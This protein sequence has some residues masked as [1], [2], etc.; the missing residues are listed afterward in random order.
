MQEGPGPAGARSVSSPLPGPPEVGEISHSMAGSGWEEKKQPCQGVGMGKD[1][2][3]LTCELRCAAL[4]GLGV[5]GSPQQ[6]RV[7]SWSRFCPVAAEP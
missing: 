1:R 4:M 5:P 7:C 3:L 2:V 6:R